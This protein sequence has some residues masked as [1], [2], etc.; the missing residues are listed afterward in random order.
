MLRV[1]P[2]SPQSLVSATVPRVLRMSP[3]MNS[4]G[5]A[6]GLPTLV[7]ALLRIWISGCT[8]APLADTVTPG[9]DPAAPVK[10]TSP[11]GRSGIIAP[12]MISR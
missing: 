5:P 3:A 7:E 6:V 4:A 11:V 12:V 8:P 2:K 1:W 9:A 10:I